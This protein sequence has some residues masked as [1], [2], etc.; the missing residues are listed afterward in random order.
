MKSIIY[1]LDITPPPPLFVCVWVVGGGVQNGE[2][3]L[4]NISK[5][6]LRVNAHLSF[7]LHNFGA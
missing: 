5:F 7:A 3:N 6:Y 1:S 4:F 2:E